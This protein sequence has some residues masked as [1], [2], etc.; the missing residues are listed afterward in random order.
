LALLLV[1]AVVFCLLTRQTVTASQTPAAPESKTDRLGALQDLVDRLRAQRQEYYL[2]KAENEA[3]LKQHQANAALLQTQLDE[4]DPQEAQLD[5][6]IRAYQ[7]EIPTLRSTLA[8][9]AQVR[10]SVAQGAAAFVTE[11]AGQVENG[12]P[13][14]QP[15]R[16]ARLQAGLPDANEAA[17]LSAA[18]Q[19]G[20]LWTYAQEELRLA[21]S[22][23]T[24]S[25]RASVEPDVTPYA[26]YFRVG[27]S[28]LG[29]VTEDGEHTA[30]WLPTL[31]GRQWQSISEPAQA[32]QVR[33][34]V[35]ILDRR[36]APDFVL[37]PIATERL[38]SNREVP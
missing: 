22:S 19:L 15:E 8:A 32:A 12:I 27:E 7:S 28:M 30:L 20:H 5:E 38:D 24:Y 10:R 34:A 1:G 23:E 14:K 37:L 3:R 36:Q 18:T 16:L 29:Y 9:K 25:D 17:S 11:Q 31:E 4:L 21:G 13:Y 35:E 6:Q 2:K 33:D 26:R